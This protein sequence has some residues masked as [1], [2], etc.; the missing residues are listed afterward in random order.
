MERLQIAQSLQEAGLLQVEGSLDPEEWQKGHI[1]PIRLN[2]E[3]L[4][5]LLQRLPFPVSHKDPKVRQ[6][7]QKEPVAYRLILV[8]QLFVHLTGR[9]PQ[10]EE[11][12]RWAMEFLGHFYDTDHPVQD[13]QDRDVIWFYPRQVLVRFFQQVA[14]VQAGRIT[15]PTTPQSANLH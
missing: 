11:D 8:F 4:S 9:K 1:P 12:I 7:A 2:G 6:L 3:H 15:A 5:N 13:D 10:P 14:A